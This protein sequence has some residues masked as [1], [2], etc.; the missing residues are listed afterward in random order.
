MGEDV[1]QR[2]P[3]AR[4]WLCILLKPSGTLCCG[5]R[6]AAGRVSM[7]RGVVSRQHALG[8]HTQQMR[9]MAGCWEL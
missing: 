4:G 1:R 8:V 9:P 2:Q 5:G 7:W 3:R 6:A